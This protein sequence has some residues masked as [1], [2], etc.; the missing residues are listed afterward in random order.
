MRRRVGWMVVLAGVSVCGQTQIDLSRQVR[1]VLPYPS[2]GTSAST[3]SGARVNVG[4]IKRVA[5]DFAGAD[6]GQQISNAFASF[7]AGVCG[8]VSIP[9]GSYVFTSSIFVPSGCSLEGAGAYPGDTTLVY[10]G[11]PATAAIV[12]MNTDM[13]PALYSSVRDMHLRTNAT[14][15]VNDGMLKWNPAAAGANKWQCFDGATYTGPTAH[16]AA[17][18]HGQ[19]DPTVLIDGKYINISSIDIDGD[20]AGI[21]P[22]QGGF[23]F[24]VYLNGCEECVVQEV[25]VAQTDD[26]FYVGTASN[27]VLF[28]QITARINRRSGFHY[29]GNNHFQCN[30][31]LFEGNQWWAHPADPNN[32]GAGIRISGEN[33]STSGTGGMF[34]STY[35]EANWVDVMSP[36]GDVGFIE[37]GGFQSAQGKFSGSKF[38]NCVIPN[39][40]LVSTGANT[41]VVV[42]CTITGDINKDPLSRVVYTNS[43]GTLVHK[44][45]TGTGNP[46]GHYY[47]E[48]PQDGTGNMFLRADGAFATNGLRLENSQAAVSPNG[49]MPSAQLRFTARKWSGGASQAASMNARAIVSQADGLNRLQIDNGASA[50]FELLENG[51]LQA[52]QVQIKKTTPTAGVATEAGTGATCAVETSNG[53][54]DMSGQLLLTTGTAGWSS[55]AQ[56]SLTFATTLGGWVTLT[57]ANAA[58]AAAMSARQVWVDRGFSHFTVFFAVAEVASTAYKF[59]WHAVGNY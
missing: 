29:R 55:G 2:G 45:W 32:F 19:I 41:E 52:G 57:P 3:Q 17:I 16:L 20:T 12:I 53:V 13:T 37:V 43:T 24:G 1:S 33:I 6:I 9:P 59:N 46:N 14:K 15:C 23:H 21:F 28:N 50:V 31:C 42:G 36:T 44:I 8:T 18:L 47:Y 22:N 26:G 30:E 54:S 58:A 40:A 5:T 38:T 10:N 34:F 48:L 49:H 56:C 7:G 27:G 51:T 11:Q 25:V 39:G 35:F 4:S